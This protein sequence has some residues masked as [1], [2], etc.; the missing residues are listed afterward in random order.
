MLQHADTRFFLLWLL[1]IGKVGIQPFAVERSK[2]DFNCGE[3][4]VGLQ[5]FSLIT[6]T[7]PEG[8]L[9]MLKEQQSER[10]SRDDADRKYRA[11]SAGPGETL[12]G[13]GDGDEG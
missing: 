2:T 8:Y 4:N 6:S 13:D 3:Y 10:S 1:E 12:F 7:N 9:T 11:A 5:I